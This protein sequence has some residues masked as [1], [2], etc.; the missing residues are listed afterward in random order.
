MPAT[1]TRKAALFRSRHLTLLMLAFMV[2]L[3]IP[4]P[5]PG[6]ADSLD[7]DIPNGHFYKQAN[8]RGG[9]GETGYSI[10]N[11][12]GIRFWDEYQRLGG[13]YVLGYPVSRRFIWDGFV[14]QA[15]QKVVF[16]WRPEVG[17]VYFVNV[18]DRMGEL[19]HDAWLDSVRQTPPGFDTSP[20]TGLS[21]EEV[22]KRHLA[23]LDA[24]PAIRAKYHADPNSILHYG[25]PVSYKD[26]GNVFVVRAQRAV[27]QQWMDDVPWARAGEVVIANGG[28]VAKEAGVYPPEA[29][30]PERPASGT[31]GPGDPGGG[32]Q[33]SRSHDWRAPGYV[34]AVGGTLYD[35][36]C[37]PLR[38]VG[39]NVPNLAYRSGLGA[40][41]EWMR[42]R[43][44]RWLR[45]FATGH[46]LSPS[47]VPQNAD[48][49]VAALRS[50]LAEVEA[51][52]ARHDS[53]ESI[54]VLVSL[55]DYYPP[56]VP[57]DRHA[58]DHPTFRESPVLP[59]PWFRAGIRSFDF[60]QEHD[61]G[62][63]Y[64][65]PNYEVYYKPWVR[66]IVSSLSE[67]RAL[68]G[69]QLGNELKARG[70]GRNGI[71]SAQAYEWYLA[72]TRDIVDTIRSLDRNH[73]VFAGAQYVAELVDWEY[74][75]QS[76]L[77]SSRVPEYQHLVQQMLDACGDHCWNA[78]SL[79]AYDFNLYPLDDAAIFSRAGVP[80][81]ATEYGFTLG[82]PDEMQQR[83]G[84]DR[85]AAVRNGLA[86]AWVAY[87]GSE[88]PRLPGALELVRSGR[89]AGIAPWGSPAPQGEWIL[90]A[91]GNRGITGT[92]DAGLLWAAWGEVADSLETANRQAGP[93]SSCLTFQSP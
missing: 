45:V 19:G 69:W 75:P 78:W 61:L 47:R 66:Q 42:Q 28:D 12:D 3:L 60:E 68:L 17:H 57:G 11:A 80:V 37:I 10:T 76:H 51:F 31:S 81:V 15:M 14:V 49:A 9:E 1:P 21:W 26:Y 67:S 71:S 5:P 86:Q 73:L 32:S 64:G 90:D 39:A 56:G 88:H 92:P 25:L 46:A 22:V 63:L 8:G 52:N 82:G 40:Q 85:A 70:S 20:D 7:Y 27:F 44:L 18:F 2:T 30:I 16:Q 50:L 79:T 93:A 35:P 74:R 55:T 6:R 89:L 53:S 13:P 54:Y 84:G 59:A 91:D 38:S 48:A 77:D 41:L 65:L 87:D 58:F 24:N 36:Q 72:F 23:L 34:S 4:L 29:I 43:H 33:P 62:R 83:F